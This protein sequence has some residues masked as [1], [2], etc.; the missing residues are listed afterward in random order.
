MGQRREG[1]VDGLRAVSRLPVLYPCGRTGRNCVPQ[2]AGTM[3]QVLCDVFDAAQPE[4]LLPKQIYGRT[5]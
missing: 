5:D 2:L 3:L 4:E 1:R